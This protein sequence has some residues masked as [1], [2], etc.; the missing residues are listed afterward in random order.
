MHEQAGDAAL[1][2]RVDALPPNGKN[3]K[4]LKCAVRGKIKNKKLN[5]YLELVNLLMLKDVKCVS[6]DLQKLKN[7]QRRYSND[8]FLHS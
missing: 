3:R 8:D 1:S 7:L 4:G 5:A 2:L 6:T